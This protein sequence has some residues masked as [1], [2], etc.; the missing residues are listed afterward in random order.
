MLAASIGNTK[1][2]IVQ[3]DVSGVSI[4]IVMPPEINSEEHPVLYLSPMSF[5]HVKI[6]FIL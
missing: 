2:F 1:E 4:G 5:T 3:T 6:F